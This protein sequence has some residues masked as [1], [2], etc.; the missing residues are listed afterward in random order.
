MRT[1]APEID[2]RKNSGPNV[3]LDGLAEDGRDLEAALLVHGR[4]GAAPEAVHN[5]FPESGCGGGCRP[6]GPRFATID[7]F[8]PPR[9]SGGPEMRVKR[10]PLR[11]ETCGTGIRLRVLPSRP[12]TTPPPPDKGAGT[13]FVAEPGTLGVLLDRLDAEPAAPVALD[14]EADS[15][16][17]YYEKV[18]LVQV[19]LGAD[20]FL[21]DPLAGVDL[22]PLFARLAGA[23]APPARSRLRPASPLPRLRVPRVGPLRHDD[24][25][26]APRREG[27][28]PRGPSRG[29]RRRLARQGA[30]ARGLERAPALR[31]DGR[32]R[33]GRRR[34][35][36]RARGLAACRPRGEGPPRLARRGVRAPRADRVPRRAARGHRERL[37]HQGLERGLGQGARLRARALGGPRGAR[38]RARP[39]AVP[40][41]SRTRGSSRPPRSRPG[42]SATSRS[43]SRDPGRFRPRSRRRSRR[44]SRPRPRSS[45]RT[46]RSRGAAS[47][48]RPI[49]RSNARWTPSRRCATRRPSRWVS[50]P[51]SSARGRRSR[52]RRACRRA[53]GRVTP[54]LLADEAG[55]SRWRAEI[56]AG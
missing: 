5:P 19:G 11:G 30:P 41:S 54:Q 1:S 42:A 56:L 17:H 48:P 4:L 49:P 2:V 15:F 27:D 43:S 39:A 16:H 51:A 31:L 35:P 34:P 6:T 37:A 25:G 10:N 9:V 47:A 29:A 21:A 50:T 20:A 33:R 24:R 32:L 40:R 3:V 18:C 52:P 14:T 46:G 45:R 7:H 26:A 55:L 22:A 13:V 28:R 23:G 38:P 53:H 44:R 12:V 8:F 36:A